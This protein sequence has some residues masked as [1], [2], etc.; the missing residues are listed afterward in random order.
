MIEN[1]VDYILNNKI[2][3]KSQQRLKSNHQNV[4]NEQIN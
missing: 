4:Y 1:Y 2:I 3:L